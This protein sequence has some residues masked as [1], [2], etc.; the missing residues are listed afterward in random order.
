MEVALGMWRFCELESC[1][2]VLVF[3]S[4]SVLYLD[5]VCM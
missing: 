1:V 3:R 2:C 5:S 4:I